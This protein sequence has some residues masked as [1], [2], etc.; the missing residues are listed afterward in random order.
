M[1]TCIICQNKTLSKVIELGH[2]PIADTFLKKERILEPQKLYPLNC[3]LCKKCG[4]IQNEYVVPP[5]ERYMENDYSYT[6]SNSKISCEHW[7]EY[8]DTV[9]NYINLKKGDHI[10]EFGSNDG[11]LLSYFQKKGAKATGIDPSPNMAKLASKRN[12]NTISGLLGKET[13]ATAIQKNSKAKLICGNNVFNHIYNLNDVMPHVIEALD[14]NGY[15]V[16]ESPYGKDIIDKFLF[17]TIYHE[18]ASYFSI[19]SV[20]F[21]FKKHGLYI[22]NIEHNL[23]HGGCIRV[24]ALKDMSKYNKKLVSRYIKDENKSGIFSLNTYK[25]FMAKIEKDKF[26]TLSLVYSLKKKNQKIAAIGAATKGNTLINYYKLDRNVLEFVTDTSKQ[27]IG[28]YTPGSLLPI[29]HDNKLSSKKIDVGLI[30]SWNIGKFLANKIK[31]INPKIKL[32]VPGE[33]KLL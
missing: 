11:L 32:I 29:Y 27:K 23:Y 19:K 8:C 28:K 7:Q 31:K 20:D 15:F 16:F 30:I 33:K 5:E 10:I 13:L 17:D 9:S 12:V 1:N 26:D 14:K 3:L 21:L 22:S 6:A 4:H 2:H 24:Y 25:K 18:H